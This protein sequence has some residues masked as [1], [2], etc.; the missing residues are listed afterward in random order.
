[1]TSLPIRLS[2]PSHGRLRRHRILAGIAVGL[3]LAAS[4]ALVASA[5]VVKSAGPYHLEIGWHVEP[6]YVG[7]PNA[8]E[9]TITDGQSKPVTDISS[10]DL[11]ATVST[12]GQSSP[13]I[14]FEPA[15]DLE[16]HDGVFGQYIAPVVP[17]APGDYTFELVGK[18]HGTSVDISVTSGETRFDAVVGTSELQF[19]AKLPTEAEV[20][21]HLDR[22]DARVQAANAAVSDASASADRALLIGGIAGAA[23]LVV[24]LV[25]LGFALRARR[26]S[27]PGS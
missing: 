18:I 26:R 17:T 24:A 22:L 12:G 25:A 8:V 14:G 27:S 10:D 19:P 11:Q 7:Q 23:G 1:M 21:T 16:E 5:H 13:K 15:F 9:V 6:A 4:Q 20:A 2:R 3:V